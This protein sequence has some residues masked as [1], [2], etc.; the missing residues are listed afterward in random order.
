MSRKIDVQTSSYSIVFPRS[1]SR[2][3]NVMCTSVSWIVLHEHCLLAFD[4]TWCFVPGGGLPRLYRAG[5]EN[6]EACRVQCADCGGCVVF[7]CLRW[8]RRRRLHGEIGRAAGS[9]G[10]PVP[11]AHDGS[12]HHLERGDDSS[13]R[14]LRRYRGDLPHGECRALR[15][16]LA[17]SQSP[18]SP[19]HA[20]SSV[21]TSNSAK[22]TLR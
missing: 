11:I 8:S 7:S 6:T 16:C 19:G 22:E 12:A 10:A 18:Q 20:N 15:R 1:S 2:R 14:L 13:E 5:D 4:G 21:H 3:K 17:A 9:L